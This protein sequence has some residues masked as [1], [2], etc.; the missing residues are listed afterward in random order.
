MYELLFNTHDVVLLITAY[1]CGLFALLLLLPHGDSRRQS[2][3]FL[4]GFLLTQA[5]IP[6]DILITFGAG[7]RQV[8]LNFSPNIFNLFDL[9][10]WL[11][12]PFLLFYTRSVVYR[13][14]HLGKIEWAYFLPFVLYALHQLFNYFAL[15]HDVKYSILTEPSLHPTPAYISKITLFREVFRVAMGLLCL[16]E[17]RR[18]RA[19]LRDEYSDTENLDLGWLNLLCFGFL[20]IRIWAVFVALAYILSNDSGFHINF[21]IMGL[22]GNYTTF[23]LVS[24]LIFYSLRMSPILQGIELLHEEPAPVQHIG[25]QELKRLESV[26]SDKKPHLTHSLTLQE[27]ADLVGLPQ[28]QLSTIINRHYDKSFFEFINFYRVEEAKKM[29][30]DRQ[31]SDSVLNIMLDSGFSSKAAFNRFFKQYVGCTPSEYR[32]N[33]SADTL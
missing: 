31:N 3:F 5:A 25:E 15:P 7:F 27:L 29:L 21:E 4:A 1:L 20:A 28:R 23:L 33:F 11:E 26:M 8:A 16:Y 13:N 6:I 18:Y 19:H 9:A 32:R 22:I 17:I 30:A 2:S 10:Y 24:L 12:G 14:Y